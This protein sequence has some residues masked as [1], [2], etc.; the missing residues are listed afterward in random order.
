MQCTK[1]ARS[2]VGSGTR[3]VACILLLIALAAM[4]GVAGCSD[5]KKTF[6]GIWKSNCDD[7]WGVLIT[8]AEGELYA[9]TFCGLSGCLEP[10]AWMPDTRI[11]GDPLYQVDS[12][13]RIRIKRNDRG[14]F[15]YNKCSAAA[16]WQVNYPSK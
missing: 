9:V 3:R 14:Y 15:T 6:T 2:S 10:G 5:R 12:A 11:E 7:Y 4:A 13:T 8:P 16:H 1:G